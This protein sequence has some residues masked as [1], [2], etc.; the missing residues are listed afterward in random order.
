VPVD[1]GGI[2]QV[3]RGG[4]GEAIVGTCSVVEVRV[5]SVL[6]VVVLL[7]YPTRRSSALASVIPF[8]AINHVQREI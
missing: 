1:V 5:F 4:I 3:M 7:V 6:S 8:I 2:V